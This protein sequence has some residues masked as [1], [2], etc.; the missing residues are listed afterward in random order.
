LK[1]VEIP[2]PLEFSNDMLTSRIKEHQRLVA[3]VARLEKEIEEAR[4]TALAALPAE[5]GYPD[6]DSFIRAVRQAAAPQRRKPVAG[7]GRTTSPSK[8]D[9][10][11]A[12]PATIH[13]PQPVLPSVPPV[14]PAPASPP[15]KPTGTSL[16]DPAHFGV[17]PDISLLVQGT[18]DLPTYQSRLSEALRFAQKVLHTSRVPAGIWREWRLFERQATDALRAAHATK[19]VSFDGVNE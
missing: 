8:A 6:L 17:L 7:K 11:K 16:D 9:T 3:Y 1:T 15:P 2:I 13:R 5:Y 18:L 12:G 4:T 10:G 14:K 19:E